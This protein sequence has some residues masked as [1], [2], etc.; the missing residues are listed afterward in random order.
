MARN[1]QLQVFWVDE[2]KQQGSTFGERLANAFEYVFDHGFQNVISIGNDTP[3]LCHTDLQRA[4]ESLIQQKAVLGPTA[5]GG[6]YLIGLNKSSFCKETFQNIPW[7]TD[8]VNDS[9]IQHFNAMGC[10]IEFM[11]T[12]EDVDHES[13]IWNSSKHQAKL[14][15][16]KVLIQQLLSCTT[17]I[18]TYFSK[19]IRSVF[20]FQKGL[21]AP[22]YLS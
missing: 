19:S 6:D 21:R 15:G 7:Q 12:L 17:L 20:L 4:A 8:A 22:P 16:L 9:L 1:S 14:Q 18:P 10:E 5:D 3:E 13:V 11:Q 2:K